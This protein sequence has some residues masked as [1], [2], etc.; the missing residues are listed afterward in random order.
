MNKILAIFSIILTFCILI[1][2]NIIEKIKS[3]DKVEEK[4]CIFDITG[5]TLLDSAVDHIKKYEGFSKCIYIDNSGHKT[6]GYGH[7]LLNGE[8]NLSL[9]TEKQATDI[10]K[11]DLKKSINYVEFTTNLRDNKSLAIGM[12]TYNVGSGVL[13]GAINDGV[14]TNIKKL[15]NYCHYKKKEGDS[16]VIITS[17][18]L[19]ERRNYE[20]SL[21]EL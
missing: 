20:I 11:S 9:I 8:N 13:Q 4:I 19:L 12:F 18:K 10:L 16:V 17:R 7:H 2:C 6:I 15:R 3:N 21:Y 1:L 5:G 14:L